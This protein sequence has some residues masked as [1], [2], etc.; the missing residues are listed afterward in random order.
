MRSLAALDE[1]PTGHGKRWSG[2]PRMSEIDHDTM[3]RPTFQARQNRGGGELHKARSFA[4]LRMQRL[5]ARKGGDEGKTI[6][7][8]VGSSPPWTQRLTRTAS[9]SPPWT[10][11]IHTYRISQPALDSTH[12]HARISQP[13]PTGRAQRPLP[14]QQQQLPR[15]RGA[16]E[17]GAGEVHPRGSHG[18][19]VGPPVPSHHPHVSIANGS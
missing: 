15:H 13:E 8:R 11:R 5:R 6:S 10:Q 18:T 19:R 16:A 3:Q 7:R 9:A 2:E 1:V 4:T 17:M 12:S 14:T